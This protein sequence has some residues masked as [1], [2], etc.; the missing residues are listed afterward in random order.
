MTDGWDN[1]IPDTH[2]SCKGHYLCKPAGSTVAV[3][4]SFTVGRIPSN[5]W[6]VYS[7]CFFF[8]KIFAPT[9][10]VIKVSSR[11][12]KFHFSLSSSNLNTK[13]S[14][15]IAADTVNHVSIELT[16]F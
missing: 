11:C 9:S 12:S 1:Q 8:S 5:S 15:Q 3:W 2:F 6:K 10:K 14:E 16:T 4:A 7:G 13:E